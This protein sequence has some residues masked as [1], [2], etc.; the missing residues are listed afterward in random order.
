MADVTVQVVCRF[1]QFGYCRFQERCRRKHINETCENENCS[2][3][4]CPKRHPRICKY[5]REFNRCKFGDF[6]NYR[7][8]YFI[9]NSNNNDDTIRELNEKICT[10]GDRMVD[11]EKDNDVLRNRVSQLEKE[12]SNLREQ[13]INHVENSVQIQVEE[14]VSER[15]K[16][17]ES[18]FE[19]LEERI[20][21]NKAF[22]NDV[23]VNSICD[24]ENYVKML[25]RHSLSPTSSKPNVKNR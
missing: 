7:H 16:H 1:H 17:V 4:E 3:R 14:A 13:L 18:N 24:L 9:S 25:P 21:N 22:M 23:I 5:F 19:I 11:L 6:C 20:K 8:K 12:L 15:M 10:H 2:S